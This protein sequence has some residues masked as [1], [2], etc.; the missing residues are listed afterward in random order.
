MKGEDMDRTSLKT[1]LAEK[2]A[3]VQ[4]LEEDVLAAEKDLQTRRNAHSQSLL[5]Q[6]SGQ[7]ISGALDNQL[8]KFIEAQCRLTGF[9]DALLEAGAEVAAC[10]KDLE[11]CQL[12]DDHVTRF[13]ESMGACERSVEILGNTDSLNQHVREV[14]VAI[15]TLFRQVEAG[16]DAIK[17]VN[18]RLDGYSL[19]SFLN[20]ELLTVENE[21][22]DA[23]LEKIGQ[24][25]KG[26]A[27]QDIRLDLGA[28]LKL[29][30]LIALFP[31]W[32]NKIGGF[33]DGKSLSLSR[34]SLQP[35]AAT[36]TNARRES[37]MSPPYY[38]DL[39]LHP[40]RFSPRDFDAA[41]RA[42]WIPEPAV[43]EM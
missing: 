24:Q 27:K 19:E 22:R 30:E 12:H 17:T 40:E 41:R 20:G 10:E 2:R 31:T 28:L 32:R 38:G 34:H 29:Q 35:R 4:S 21:D 13:R 39:E 16:I 9:K 14:V 3:I 8:Q 43:E 7:R 11:L 26:Y 15:E 37:L 25:I 6:K 42:Q 23:I 33:R 18:H 1:A 5:R 36:K